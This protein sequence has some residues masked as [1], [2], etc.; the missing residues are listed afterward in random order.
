MVRQRPFGYAVL[1]FW[2]HLACFHPPS[3]DRPLIWP[4]GRRLNLHM[5]F[6]AVSVNTTLSFN[7]MLFTWSISNNAPLWLYCKCN[8]LD[9]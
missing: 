7:R 3:A 2:L 4:N 1:I 9:I 6:T 8:S 5:V